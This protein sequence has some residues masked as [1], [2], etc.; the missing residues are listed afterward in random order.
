L[1]TKKRQPARSAPTWNV[2][3]L[4]SSPAAF[5]GRVVAKHQQEAVK[6]AIVEYAV[7]PRFW[8]RLFA[9]KAA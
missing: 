1:R 3:R 8:Q 9:V 7:P 6:A 5:I 4:K 2:H